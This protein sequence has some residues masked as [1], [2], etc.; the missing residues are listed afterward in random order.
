MGRVSNLRRHQPPGVETSSRLRLAA[1]VAG[2]TVAVVAGGA[3]MAGYVRLALFVG[4]GILGIVYVGLVFYGAARVIG[5]L[6]G[7]ALRVPPLS[8]LRIVQFH[9]ARVERRIAHV[10]RAFAAVGWMLML[11]RHF[12]LW[13]TAADLADASLAAEVQRGALSLSFGNVGVFVITVVAT[14]LLSAFV[15]FVLEEEI[16]PRVAPARTLPYAAS[17]LIH[18][19]LVFTGFLLGLA[20]LGIDLSKLAIIAGGLGVGIGLGLQG[21]V[22]NF[23]SGIVVLYERRINVGDAVQLGDIGGRVQQ[24]GLRACTV[25]TWEGAEVI[26]PNATLTTDRVTNW[27]LSDEHRRIDLPVGVA[28]GTA[29]EKVADL[30]LTVARKHAY[31]LAEPAP[32]VLFRGFGDSAL[33]FEVRVWTNHFDA[34]VQTQ[35]E[36]TT[37]VY[38]ALREAAIEIPFPQRDVHIK[39]A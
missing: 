32:V 34:W 14:F 6:I 7:A 20:A 33:L 13:S 24:M 30:L 8:H 26:V 12:G 15:R 27:T 4:G 25:R 28:Y 38:A 5:A 10:L 21:L 19:T 1:V 29:P 31:V 2:L 18:Y 16:Y 23:V 39:P 36:L 17:T 37:A 11:L 9:R 35:S 3:A 22:N